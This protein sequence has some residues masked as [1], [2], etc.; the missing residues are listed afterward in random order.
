[1]SPRTGRPP[2]RTYAIGPLSSSPS[3]TGR[4]STRA[5]ADPSVVGGAS[6]LETDSLAPP[7]QGFVRWYPGA[8]WR[9]GMR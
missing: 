8:R 2:G 1:V 5:P 4:L 9:A 6:A 3:R 7:A